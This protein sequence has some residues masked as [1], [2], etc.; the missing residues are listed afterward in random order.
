MS[1][2]LLH[3]LRCHLQ[4]VRLFEGLLSPLSLRKHHCHHGLS[5]LNRSLAGKVRPLL[6]HICKPIKDSAQGG[7]LML[8]KLLLASHKDKL[9][10]DFQFHIL[11][12]SI[13]I[14]TGIVRL[15]PTKSMTCTGRQRLGENDVS[16]R[17]KL[18]CESSLKYSAY[19]EIFTPSQLVMKKSGGRL[20]VMI[21]SMVKPY[22][23]L[24]LL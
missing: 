7:V 15:P 17:R 18:E 6:E 14:S 22:Y 12:I 8:H 13:S 21:L 3:M 5:Q 19:R 10:G 11:F 20:D 24:R 23:E 9:P 16:L 1:S 2:C 4:K